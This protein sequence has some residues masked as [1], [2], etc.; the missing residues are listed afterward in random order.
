MLWYYPRAHKEIPYTALHY[1]IVPTYSLSHHYSL[2]VNGL[3][4]ILSPATQ[5]ADYGVTTS[6][7]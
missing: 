4:L 7:R 5:L 2:A 6:Q 3:L 1:K